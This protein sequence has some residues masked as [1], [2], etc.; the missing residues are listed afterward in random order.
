VQTASGY[1]PARVELLGNHTDYNQGVVLAAAID[2]GLTV[3][4]TQRPDGIISIASEF[5]HNRVEVPPGARSP[6]PA[7]SWANYPLGVVQQ[8][9]LAG[10]RIGGFDATVSGDVPAGAG[11]SSSAAFELA[12]AGFLMALH[13]IR[14]EPMVV[15]KLCQRAENEFVG[16]RSGLLDQATSVFGRANHVVHLDFQSEEIRTI[17]F[18]AG[19]S[20]IIANSGEQHQ[21][22][23]SEY[24][25]RREE[26]AAAAKALGV[27]SLREVS[28]ARLETA[29]RALDPILFRR[30]A[31]IVGENERVAQALDA[32]ERGDA[33][34]L[35]SL[36]N[37]SHE[38]S[39]VNFEN[40]TPALDRLVQV[41]RALPGVFGSRLTGGGFGGGTVTLVETEAAAD[42][43]REMAGHSPL[44]FVCRTADGAATTWPK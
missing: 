17:P 9:E 34:R 27:A 25:T 26:C 37:A 8:F 20:L 16:V 12:T 23:Q 39:R 19:V 29:R 44:A 6:L 4:G 22:Q 11:L 32:L 40:S 33:G 5:S 30:A 36:M 1:A 13:G 15:A 3:T 43:A 38:S 2:R 31:H 18:P 41:A 21:L 14:L 42:T 24:N 28:S 35:G 10:H 7:G